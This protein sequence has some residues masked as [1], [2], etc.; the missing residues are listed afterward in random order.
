MRQINTVLV[1]EEW[2]DSERFPPRRAGRRAGMRTADGEQGNTNEVH[3][4]ETMS[5]SLI[6]VCR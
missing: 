5:L 3:K 1:C 2:E 6:P 4:T